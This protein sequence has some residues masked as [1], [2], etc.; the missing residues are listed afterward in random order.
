MLYLARPLIFLVTWKLEGF[1]WETGA[2]YLHIKV[3]HDIVID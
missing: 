2:N 1:S 3:R